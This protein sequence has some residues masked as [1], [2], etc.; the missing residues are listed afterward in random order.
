MLT[1]CLRTSLVMLFLWMLTFGVFYPV[2]VTGMAQTFFPFKANGSLIEGEQHIPIGSRLIGQN[3]VDPRYFWGR[4][5]AIVTRPYDAMASAGS[6]LGPLN[7][8]L[9]EI[10]QQRIQKLKAADPSNALSIPIDLVT[11]SGSGLDPEIS[12][13]AA[14]YQI[15]RVAFQRHLTSKKVE[16][17]LNRLQ[18]DRQPFFWQEPRVNVLELNLALDHLCFP[19]SCE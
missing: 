13:A 12:I 16:A 7:P 14:R 3:F 19:E 2:M 9:T 15:S 10:I 4:P 17:L 11:A 18:V 8:R 1:Q 5:S 6:N